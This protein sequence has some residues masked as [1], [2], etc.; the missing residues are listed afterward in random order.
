MK[1]GVWQGIA[2]ALII[3][4]SISLIACSALENK[5]AGEMPERDPVSMDSPASQEVQ[6]H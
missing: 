2:A 3:A 5:A 4:V 6:K 1:N